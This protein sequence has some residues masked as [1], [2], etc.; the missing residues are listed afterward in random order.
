VLRSR[1]AA[2]EAETAE[3]AMQ[4]D[5]PGLYVVI[6]TVV[7]T[8][9]VARS[10]HK[11]QVTVLEIVR[12]LTEKRVRGRIERPAGWISLLDREDGHRWALKQVRPVPKR[13]GSEEAMGVEELRLRL[14]GAQAEKG[15]L[16]AQVAELRA[17]CETLEA[18]RRT[19]QRSRRFG[20]IA[21]ASRLSGPSSHCRRILLAAT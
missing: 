19:L 2:L 3:V 1:C 11:I 14:A 5:S 17:N 6:N 8:S 13:I 7:V 4:I 18:E 9:D 21:L 15:E 16:V 12:S 20:A 10:S